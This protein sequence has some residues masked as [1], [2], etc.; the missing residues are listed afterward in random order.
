MHDVPARSLS[1]L[2]EI[3][4]MGFPLLIVELSPTV[5]NKVAAESC[6]SPHLMQEFCRWL[7]SEN[8]IMQ[9]LP[10]KKKTSRGK[11]LAR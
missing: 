2:I 5:A 8:G 1:E 4:Q 3:P 6:E 10:A 11:V 9:T 7:A